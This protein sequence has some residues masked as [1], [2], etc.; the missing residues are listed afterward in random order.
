MN[1]LVRTQVERHLVKKRQNVSSSEIFKF[2]F[3]KIPYK[4]DVVQ[5][6]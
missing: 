4:K 3:A 6:K 1:S 5:Q 2:L